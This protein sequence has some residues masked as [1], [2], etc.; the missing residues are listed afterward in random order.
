MKGLLLAILLLSFSHSKHTLTDAVGAQLYV[1]LKAESLPF[2]GDGVADLLPTALPHNADIFLVHGD[3]LCCTLL[4]DRVSW[5]SLVNLH[6]WGFLR[7][8]SVSEPWAFLV[9][10]NHLLKGDEMNSG[11]FVGVVPRSRLIA[12][13]ELLPLL[14]RSLEWHPHLTEEF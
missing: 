10:R 6:S 12:H 11:N 1:V 9:E 5:F 14:L 4:R 2:D 7:H 8:F 13:S 3:E